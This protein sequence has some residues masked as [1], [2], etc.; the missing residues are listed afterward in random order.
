MAVLLPYNIYRSPKLLQHM[1][2]QKL[3]QPLRSPGSDRSYEALRTLLDGMPGIRDFSAKMR[4]AYEMLS[5]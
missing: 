5:I 1:E 2:R 4:E 3:C